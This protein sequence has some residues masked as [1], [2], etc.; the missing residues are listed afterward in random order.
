M[1]HITGE[2]DGR[3]EPPYSGSNIYPT[4]PPGRNESSVVLS[5]DEFRVPVDGR[6]E[7]RCIVKGEYSLLTGGSGSHMTWWLPIS[8]L[9]FW[10][11]IRNFDHFVTFC[12]AAVIMLYLSYT[13]ARNNFLGGRYWLLC[14]T[15]HCLQS[16]SLMQICSWHQNDHDFM[17]KIKT[18]LSISQTFKNGKM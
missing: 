13:K 11:G 18:L 16:F 4:Y 14:H 3:P 12:Y 17:H 8:R 9:I 7:M 1:L 10:G 15:G 2:H 5:D 6:A